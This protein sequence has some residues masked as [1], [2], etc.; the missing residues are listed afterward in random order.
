MMKARQKLRSVKP[1]TE[2]AK[3]SGQRPGINRGQRRVQTGKDGTTRASKDVTLRDLGDMLREAEK[4][5]HGA[6]SQYTER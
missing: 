6:D 2:N 4:A 3:Q 5:G 1:T